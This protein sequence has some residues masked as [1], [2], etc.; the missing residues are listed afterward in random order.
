MR[1]EGSKSLNCRVSFDR[2]VEEDTKHKYLA[3]IKQRAEKT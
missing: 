2:N 1:Y 3:A